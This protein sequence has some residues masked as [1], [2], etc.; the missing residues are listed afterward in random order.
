[1]ELLRVEYADVELTEPRLNIGFKRLPRRVPS[2]IARKCR[3]RVLRVFAAIVEIA[4][5]HDCPSPAPLTDRAN[6]KALRKNRVVVW[7]ALSLCVRG[8]KM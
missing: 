1:M 7:E 6:I 2:N 4:N 8:H 5:Q 3:D